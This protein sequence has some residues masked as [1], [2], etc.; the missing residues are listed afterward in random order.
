MAIFETLVDGLRRAERELEAQLS[1]IKAAISS[2]AGG[3]G[4][5]RKRGRPAGSRNRRKGSDKAIIIVGGKVKRKRRKM[6]VAARKKISD[7]QKKR[8]ALQKS[9]AKRKRPALSE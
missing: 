1:G 7:A 2:L 6:S 4:T 9:G 5:G 8:W 3:S